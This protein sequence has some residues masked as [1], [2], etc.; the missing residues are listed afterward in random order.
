MGVIIAI[1]LIGIS[2]LL[3]A[4]GHASGIGWLRYPLILI[5]IAIK[6]VVA[7]LLAGVVFVAIYYRPTVETR[8]LTV[9]S[10][11]EALPETIWKNAG[12]RVEARTAVNHH[13]GWRQPLGAEYLRLQFLVAAQQA[14][15]DS[16]DVKLDIR[17]ASV[18]AT[19]FRRR[20]F[21]LAFEHAPRG[22]PSRDR[23]WGI[24]CSSLDGDSFF[25]MSY[26]FDGGPT[27]R[28]YLL[29][30][31]RVDIIWSGMASD[32]ETC[33]QSADPRGR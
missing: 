14:Q 24:S 28:V 10:A 32:W 12:L 7:L 18:E 9:V 11:R 15:R 16:R 26:V 19:E 20:L 23:L 30:V 2:T 22:F 27:G 17:Q 31:S 3:F 25:D 29:Q 4:I 6:S 33:R 1:Y 21:D 5:G 8:E 13:F